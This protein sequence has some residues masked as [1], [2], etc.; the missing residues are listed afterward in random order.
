[1][2]K[3][4]ALFTLLLFTTNFA[5]AKN[6]NNNTPKIN[7]F[8]DLGRYVETL[9][10][11]EE[12]SIQNIQ[13]ENSD[14]NFENEA[15]ENV[16]K[17]YEE[18]TVELKLDDV[19]DEAINTVNSS[20]IFQLKV[21]ETQYRIEN[22][23][24]AENMIWDSS[25][26][27]SQAFINNSRHLAPIPSV[28]NSS[29]INAQ[30]SNSVSAS[31]GQ[32]FLNDAIGTSV[33]FVRANESTYNTGAVLKYKGDRLNIATGSFTSSFNQASSGG[34]I[35]S[36][37]EINLP[38][39]TGSFILGGAYMA[40]EQQ[41]FDKSTGG[42]FAEYRFK[43]LKLNAQAAQ[44]KYTNSDN[45]D[46]SLY[47][48]P[49]LQLTNSLSLKTRFIRNLSQDTMQDELVLNFKPKNNN[50]NLEL[51]LSATNKYTD[52]STINQR[53]KFSTSFKI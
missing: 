2:K 15:I 5:F 9:E 48:V 21:N 36:S 43:R 29:K 49:E 11:N 8:T 51:E 44:S 10:I 6:S 22:N 12:E 52:S 35:I 1:M 28:I 40:N 41:D 24:K 32:T 45:V 31:L 17:R 16:L 3:I 20:R 27:F 23:I 26:S 53:I 38:M 46:T 47:L 13:E 4:V 33:I 14:D 39:N 50:H 42:F 7:N 19:N 34:A 30:V 25:K 18:N 37:N